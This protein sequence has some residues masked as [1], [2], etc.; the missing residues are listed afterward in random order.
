M[1]FAVLEQKTLAE[2]IQRLSGDM[3][4]MRFQVPDRLSEGAQDMLKQLLHP[5]PKQRIDTAGEAR[6]KLFKPL[7][8]GPALQA[9]KA[10]LHHTFDVVLSQ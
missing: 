4:Q 10:L 2:R 5:D 9:R 6:R 8:E 3:Q 1:P 7:Q